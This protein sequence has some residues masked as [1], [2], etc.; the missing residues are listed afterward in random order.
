MISRPA[1]HPN[2]GGGVIPAPSGSLRRAGPSSHCEFWASEQI[3]SSGFIRVFDMAEGHVVSSENLIL[4]ILKPG[5]KK[6]DSKVS[7]HDR[8]DKVF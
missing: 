7:I 4:D 2:K 5:F 8:F 3:I 1:G 6:T